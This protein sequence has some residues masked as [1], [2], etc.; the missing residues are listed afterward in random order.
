MGFYSCLCFGSE[1]DNRFSN[2]VKDGKLRFLS[3]WGYAEST[4][5]LDVITY[6]YCFKKHV[7]KHDPI[8]M[9]HDDF[10]GEIGGLGQEIL[11]ANSP[12]QISLRDYAE[13]YNKMLIAYLNE[14]SMNECERSEDLGK[15]FDELTDFVWSMDEIGKGISSVGAPEHLA[16]GFYISLRDKANY[17]KL[18][19]NSCNYFSQND[20]RR[21]VLQNA[22]EAANKRGA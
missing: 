7:S 22:R 19:S 20:I 2:D 21:E 3:V 13:A 15:A 14:K 12:Q 18:K 5:G 9:R 16:D 10:S 6:I 17:H 8:D 1:L 11:T 4:P